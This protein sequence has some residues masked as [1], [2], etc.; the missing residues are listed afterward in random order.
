MFNKPLSVTS[1]FETRKSRFY[2]QKEQSKLLMHFFIACEQPSP[3][4][5]IC[6]RF[7]SEGKGWLYNAIF[8][9]YQ[10]MSSSE[11]LIISRQ[12]TG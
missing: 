6:L 1:E 9:G 2:L 10:N 5:I 7:F 3:S 8:Q 11:L 12:M 4:L